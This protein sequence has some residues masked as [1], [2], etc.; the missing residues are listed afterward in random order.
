MAVMDGA[1]LDLLAVTPRVGGATKGSG[2]MEGLLLLH[3]LQAALALLPGSEYSLAQL[4][5]VSDQAETAF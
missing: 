1:H 3:Q 2:N 4:F 5:L